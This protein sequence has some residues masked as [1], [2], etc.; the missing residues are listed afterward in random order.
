MVQLRR[1]GFCQKPLAQKADWQLAA[2]G[3]PDVAMEVSFPGPLEVG[4]AVLQTAPIPFLTRRDSSELLNLPPIRRKTS[5]HD[6]NAVLRASDGPHRRNCFNTERIR[7]GPGPYPCTQSH[8]V[9]ALAVSGQQIP[10]VVNT[11]WHPPPEGL[12]SPG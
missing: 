8:Y 7:S 1:E 2:K 9:I 11:R 3:S 10:V 5:Q 4:G 12:I 6:R